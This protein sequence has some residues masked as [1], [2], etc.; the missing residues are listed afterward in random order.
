[1]RLSPV[2][3]AVFI[4]AAAFSFASAQS[5]EFTPRD[6]TPEE[7]PAGPGRDEAF[8]SCVACHNFKLVAAQ[9]MDRERWSATL[10]FMTA[11]H[12]MPALE[13][14]DRKLVLDY[15]ATA[16]PPKAPAAAGG[17]KSPFAPK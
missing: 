9:G 1:M 7:F 8:Y 11:R 16:F 10:D 12:N 2:A 3:A 5:P 14:D 17:W 13:G 15:L 6:E 4:A